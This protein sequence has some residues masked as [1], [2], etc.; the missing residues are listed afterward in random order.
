MPCHYSCQNCT[1]ARNQ[2]RCSR[3]DST[4]FRVLTGTSCPCQDGYF[5]NNTLLCIICNSSCL[6]CFN[7][8]PNGCLSCNAT[9]NRILVSAECICDVGYI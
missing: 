9:L 8:L 4:Y 6:T 5:D 3:C 2:S 7:E 1:S